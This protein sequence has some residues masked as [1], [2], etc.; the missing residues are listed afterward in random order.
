MGN[1]RRID[2]V[3]TTHTEKS[4]GKLIAKDKLIIVSL[5]ELLVK[6]KYPTKESRAA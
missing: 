1:T 6:M 2:M 4:V 5:L 3:S